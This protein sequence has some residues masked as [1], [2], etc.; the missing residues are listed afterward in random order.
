M[1]PL[2][3]FLV[4]DASYRKRL[5]STRADD[6]PQVTA[7]ALETQGQSYAQAIGKALAE[8]RID[9]ATAEKVRHEIG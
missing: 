7:E 5:A 4:C 9:E 1:T 3:E 8:G 6:W 2:R